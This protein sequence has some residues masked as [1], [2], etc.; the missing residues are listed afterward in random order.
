MRMLAG[1]RGPIE[2][3]QQ[4]RAKASP[5]E[6]KPSMRTKLAKT[7]TWRDKRPPLIVGAGNFTLTW[8]DYQ[9][10][11]IALG[12]VAAIVIYQ[13]LRRFQPELQPRRG[14]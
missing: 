11:G 10:A 6:G 13:V 5:N 8:G 14:P 4:D 9:F 7:G 2:A 3:G 12:T 1:H